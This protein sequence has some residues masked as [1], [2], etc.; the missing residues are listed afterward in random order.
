MCR[1]SPFSTTN[2]THHR[3]QSIQSQSQKQ[4]KK[5]EK[6]EGDRDGWIKSQNSD[7]N[8]TNRRSTQL[9]SIR[10]LPRQKWRWV[11]LNNS[12]QRSKSIRERENEE[13][14]VIYL[15]VPMAL[16]TFIPSSSPT[17]W[18]VTRPVRLFHWKKETG[19]RRNGICSL[20]FKKTRAQR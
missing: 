18:P 9:D 20:S 3:H 6:M 5:K 7:N 17:K 2:T 4:E 13:I 1:L 14:L 16:N 12:K 10:C 11:P 15:S 19:Q 8:P